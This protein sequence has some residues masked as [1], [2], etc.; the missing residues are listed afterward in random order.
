MGYAPLA[1]TYGPSGGLLYPLYLLF[2]SLL[3]DLIPCTSLDRALLGALPRALG[4][5]SQLP[6]PPSPITFYA[7]IGPI[8]CLVGGA[9]ASATYLLFFR[10][11][12]R[13]LAKTRPQQAVEPDRHPLGCGEED[14]RPFLRPLRH[15]MSSRGEMERKL[16]P[17]KFRSPHRL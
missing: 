16:G 7:C 13:L 1:F 9:A 12:T 4:R 17:M 14:R 10:M 6:G 2:A 11:G 3:L 15:I 5:L 8:G